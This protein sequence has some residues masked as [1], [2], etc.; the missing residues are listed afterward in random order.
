MKPPYVVIQARCQA[1]GPFQVERKPNKRSDAPKD[2][3]GFYD[4]VKCPKC[5]WWATIVKQY[6]ITGIDLAKGP[7]QTVTMELPLK[8]KS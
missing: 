1:H 2:R 6:M 5:P 4:A 3:Q 7:D 8:V